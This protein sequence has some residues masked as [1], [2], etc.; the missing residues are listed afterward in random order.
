MPRFSFLF[1]LLCSVL[2]VG[3]DGCRW[4]PTAEE[5]AEEKKALP[6]FTSL[7]AQPFPADRNPSGSGIKPGH[8]FSAAQV[9][10]SNRDDTRGQLE[11]RVLLGEG[12]KPDSQPDADSL[13]N[14]R[15]IVLPKGQQRRFDYRNLAP[16]QSRERGNFFLSSQLFSGTSLVHDTGAERIA[17]LRPEE[18]FFIILTNRPQ[19][20]AKLLS[21]DWR[22]PFRSD[23]EF[24]SKSANYRF[25]IPNTDQVLPVAESMLDWTSTAVVLWD[26]VSPD[27]LTPG[28]SRAMQ[29][30]IHF[31]GR[32]IVNGADAADSIAASPL[33][34]LLP[35]N[36]RGNIELDSEAATQLLTHW[37]VETDRS[38]E[39]QV[40]RVKSDSGRIA[41]DGIVASDAIDVPGTGH[42]MLNRS[43]GRGRVMQ[44]R[45]DLVS[46]WMTNWDSY[47][48]FFNAV[49]LERPARRFVE[50]DQGMMLKQQYVVS[51][52]YDADPTMNSTFRIAARDARLRLPAA[53]PPQKQIASPPAS[54]EASND[55]SAPKSNA[56][57][58]VP[59]SMPDRYTRVDPIAGTSGWSHQSDAIQLTQEIL[60]NES[61]I[62]IPSSSLVMRSL[63]IYLLV[64]VPL[65]Y[66]VFLLLGKLEYAW[67]AV[68]LIAVLGA[69]WVARSAQL[70][71]GFARSQTEI[72]ILE[73]QPEYDR[74]HLSRVIAI[75]NS[76]S[77]TYDLQFAT[78]DA[79]ANSLA[80][81]TPSRTSS[82]LR[83]NTDFDEGPRLAGVA[84]GSNETQMVRAEQLVDVGG[85][86]TLKGEELVN[87][88]DYEL[89]DSF[90]V[91]KIGSDQTRV[92]IVGRCESGARIKLRFQEPS[93]S[94]GPTELPLQVS[95]L[96]RALLDEN[97]VPDDSVRLVGRI[98]QSLPGMTV[99]PVAN[100]RN[101][102]TIVL[103]NLSHPAASPAQ[104][105]VNLISD[106]RPSLPEASGGEDPSES[107][108]AL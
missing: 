105:D 49:I 70:D 5:E 67:L 83:F 82:S 65:N 15:P 1:A 92:A 94:W 16:G 41:V 90:V 69:A 68:P 33:A 45:F 40:A 55:V 75:Y 62:E 79:V 35:L 53:D 102:Q 47:D 38:S 95:T 101:A 59:A 26:D 34:G 2:I 91:K 8:W 104:K 56:D 50:F 54:L 86:I 18:Y 13:V 107:E 30:W 108:D 100:Q 63:G 98:E 80:Q 39:G 22:R 106:F 44:S 17:M 52:R 4:T 99:S 24:A 43:V 88:T 42:L 9:L 77:S 81:S 27:T 76:L 19:R 74:A 48:S 96:M 21:S 71:I 6:D 29:D 103:A 51:N 73:T 46:D 25:V 14:V 72:A 28:Q 78:H 20:F 84:V 36:P 37:S 87:G 7:S 97:S 3:C 61:G 11:S 60:R 66:L 57:S 85:G 58:I 64:L 93:P 31:G 12:A 89:L 10:K 23:S 32:L